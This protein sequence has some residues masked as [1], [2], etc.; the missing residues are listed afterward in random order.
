MPF[1][2]APRRRG[3]KQTLSVR[4]R[5]RDVRNAVITESPAFAGDDTKK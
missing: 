4:S 1:Y 2:D 5:W 3:V